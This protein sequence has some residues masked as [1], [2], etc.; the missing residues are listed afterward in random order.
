[1]ATTKS[2]IVSQ[3]IISD[4]LFTSALTALFLAT[5]KHTLNKAVTQLLNST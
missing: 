2:K 1:M 4:C 3:K 5:R